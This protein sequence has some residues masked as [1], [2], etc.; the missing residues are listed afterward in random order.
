VL[1]F[2]L[3]FKIMFTYQNVMKCNTL[4]C[5]KLNKYDN[6]Y[7]VNDGNVTQVEASDL[8]IRS[9]TGW[10]PCTFQSIPAVSIPEN[11]RKPPEKT[12]IRE[13]VFRSGSHHT[14]NG[15]FQTFP[16]TRKQSDRQRIL[17]EKIR[18]LQELSIK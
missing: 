11:D 16:P 2:I 6:M 15:I 1:E 10:K 5:I 7:V 12:R 8:R 17:P 3:I 13:T 4:K 9:G 18:N 14:G